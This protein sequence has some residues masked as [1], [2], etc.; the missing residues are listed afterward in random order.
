[1]K[2]C[3]WLIFYDI[4]DPKRLRMTEKAVSQYGVRIQRS[5]FEIDAG[6]SI[7]EILRK[8]LDAIIKEDD[9]AVFI[10]LCEQDWQKAEK[11]DNINQNRYI[12]RD[13]AIL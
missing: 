6:D 11:H 13:Y 12:N 10:P 1:M 7:I 3:H 9:C 5:V 2:H 8:K 4:C